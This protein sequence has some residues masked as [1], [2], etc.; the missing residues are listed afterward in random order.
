MSSRGNTTYLAIIEYDGTQY[1]GWHVQP[2]R[3]TVQA[4]V[5]TALKR[6]FG[7]PSAITVTGRT[8]AGVHA[9][10]QAVSF[11]A[12]RQIPPSNVQRALNR[13]LPPD[14][15]VTRVRVMPQGFNARRHALKKTYEYHIWNRHYRS[16][17]QGQNAWH[18]KVPLEISLMR[19]AARK[20]TGSHDFSAFDAKNSA[21]KDKVARLLSIQINSRGGAV[22][23]TF[24]GTRFLYKMVRNMVGTLVD[25][26]TGKTKPE[27]VAVILGSKKRALAGQTAPAHG[28]F[29]KKIYFTHEK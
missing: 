10:A 7:K 8:D 29:L 13:Y 25:V 20:L 9:R 22:T 15:S 11:Q 16:V 2:G 14:I 17:W 28:L 4:E 26:G 18:I 23:I 19:K 5:T 3:R 27:D 21:L 24:T 1:S 6:L 12:A